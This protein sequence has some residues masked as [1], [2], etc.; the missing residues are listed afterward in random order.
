MNSTVGLKN[1]L[2]LTMVPFFIYFPCSGWGILIFYN[3][4]AVEFFIPLLSSV[5][6]WV[7]VI[8]WEECQIEVYR[9]PCLCY[10]FLPLF[11]WSGV[12]FL[13]LLSIK[14]SCSR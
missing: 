11:F 4:S 7:L 13:Y 2:F 5:A 1:S 6:P 10:D 9:I 14:F 3:S 8:V 12:T